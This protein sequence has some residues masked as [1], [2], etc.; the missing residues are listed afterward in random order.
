MDKKISKSKTLLLI[1]QKLQPIPVMT[2]NSEYKIKYVRGK[3]FIHHF[4]TRDIYQKCPLVALLG[5]PV[6]TKLSRARLIPTTESI[7]LVFR[8]FN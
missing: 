3:P 4:Y 5:A 6:Q 2:S 1:G 8:M 7:R